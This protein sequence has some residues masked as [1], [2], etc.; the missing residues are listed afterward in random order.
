MEFCTWLELEPYPC[1]EWRLVLF[2][3]YL[4]LTVSTAD[5]IKSYC[6]TIAEQH[7]MYGYFPVYRGRLYHKAIQGIRRLLQHETKRAQPVTLE[8]LLQMVEH[9]DTHDN[10]QLA[11]WVCLLFGFFLFMR[12]SNLVPV[13]RQHDHLHQLSRADIKYHRDVV[14]V[15]VKWSKTNQ[16]GNGRLPVPVVRHPDPTICPVAWLLFM[17][18]QI[19]AHGLHNLFCYPLPNG[20]VVPVTYA[21]LT[22]L[23]RS[24][25]QKIGVNDVHRFSSH[26]LRR[27]GCSHAFSKK[28]PET[29]IQTLGSW[30]SDAYKKYIDITLESRLKAWY[31]MSQ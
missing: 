27:G 22:E 21:D 16:F 25:L 23:L 10:K 15:E 14:I 24:L 3:T 11:T 30:A 31:M 28:I 4:S 26:S 5:A 9:V 29:L 17:I 19:P 2:A 1:D 20:E 8:M 12:K 13:N 7:E 6:A 18:R